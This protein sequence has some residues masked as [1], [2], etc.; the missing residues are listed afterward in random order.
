[1]YSHYSDNPHKTT[2]GEKI[3]TAMGTGVLLLVL[4]GIALLCGVMVRL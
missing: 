4:S 2:V 3:A 1:M